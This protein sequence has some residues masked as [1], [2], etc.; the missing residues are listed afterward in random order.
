[1]VH[2]RKTENRKTGRARDYTRKPETMGNN[3]EKRKTIVWYQYMQAGKREKSCYDHMR[4][5]M[6]IEGQGKWKPGPENFE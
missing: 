4:E 3:A 1:M 2:K 5:K 6:N